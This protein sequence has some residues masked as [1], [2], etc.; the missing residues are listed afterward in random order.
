MSGAGDLATPSY[1]QAL[2]D[3]LERTEPEL[4]AWFAESGA[5]TARRDESAEVELLKSVYRLDGGVHDVLAGHATLLADRLHI[6]EPVVLYQELG[7][8]GRNARVFRLNDRIHVVFSGD[9]L[10]LLTGDEQQAIL[11]HELAHVELWNRDDGRY[12]VLDHLIHRLA[13]EP[14]AADTVGET[15]RR[16]RLHTEVWADAAAADLIESIPAVVASIVKVN[17]GIRHVEA[18]AYLR[19]AAEILE[20]DPAASQAWTHPELHIRVACIE[21]RNRHTSGATITALVSG[22]DDLDRLDLLGQVR[23]R[24]LTARV[25]RSGADRAAGHEAQADGETADGEE[26]EGDGVATYVRSYPDL[27]VADAAPIGDG[28]LADHQASIRWLAAAVLVDLALCEGRSDGLDRI[29]VLAREAERQ[30]VA[31]EFERVLTRATDRQT[32]RSVRSGGGDR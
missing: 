15:A 31:D 20:M 1:H 11:A 7:D 2:A 23:V 22:P 3:H 14:G 25:L 9:L 21:A 16:L 18:D 13:A 17:A 30:G 27:T 29:R 10:D 12:L 5:V 28:E 19:Q 26:G 32:A 6:E 24:D 4:W 8:D